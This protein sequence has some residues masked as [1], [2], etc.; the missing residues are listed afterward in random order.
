MRAKAA[1]G[2]RLAARPGRGA[3][4]RR[5]AA[6]ACGAQ[7]GTPGAQGEPMSP[8]HATAGVGAAE[9]QTA[10]RSSVRSGKG[11]PAQLHKRFASRTLE[12]V[13]I[14]NALPPDAARAFDALLQ[15]Q[16]RSERA[17]RAH[18]TVETDLGGP[19]A[20]ERYA[21]DRLGRQSPG[22]GGGRKRPTYTV[23]DA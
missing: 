6:S 7:G 10:K 16:Y 11:R 12:D 15:Q 17:F 13:E 22:A 1:Y 9:K 8:A 21:A 14:L 18:C 23:D 3:Q 19:E 5:R 20:L 2:P 4:A